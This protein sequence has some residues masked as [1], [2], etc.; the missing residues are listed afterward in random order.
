MPQR[1]KSKSH[2]TIESQILRNYWN[3]NAMLLKQRSMKCENQ[4]R[5]LDKLQK[6]LLNFHDE[7]EGKLYKIDILRQKFKKERKGNIATVKKYS[8]FM[9]QY[10]FNFLHYAIYT[11]QIILSLNYFKFFNK[12]FGMLSD[13]FC[14]STSSSRTHK[15]I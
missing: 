11:P 3:S 2:G 8:L 12:T 7:F 15:K 4:V 10:W 9:I 1:V 14:I 6:V 5:K 13:G